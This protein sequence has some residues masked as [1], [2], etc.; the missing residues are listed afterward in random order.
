MRIKSRKYMKPNRK[1]YRRIDMMTCYFEET[2]SGNSHLKCIFIDKIK[3]H[4]AEK[5]SKSYGNI[6]FADYWLETVKDN[7]KEQ[8][9]SSDEGLCF[10]RYISLLSNEKTEDQQQ[11]FGISFL[12]EQALFIEI[13]LK[14]DR[15]TEFAAELQEI[16]NE[17]GRVFYTLGNADLVLA[18]AYDESS[19]KKQIIRKI[20]EVVNRDDVY[21]C[22]VLFGETENIDREGRIRICTDLILTEKQKNIKSRLE[23]KGLKEKDVNRGLKK[24]EKDLVDNMEEYSENRN[25]KMLAF[26]QSLLRIIRLMMQQYKKENDKNIFYI[27][28]PQVVLFLQLLGEGKKRLEN[29]EE[30][31][32]NNL[33]SINRLPYKERQVKYEAEVSLYNEEKYRI[34][35][36]I[37]QAFRDFID[38][39]EIL[40]H[41]VGHSSESVFEDRSLDLFLDDIP[42][43]LCFL[44][45]AYM[46][47]VTYL[48]SDATGNEYQYCLSPLAYSIPETECFEFGLPPKSR[49][50]K[51]MIS[52]HMMFTPRSLFII[53]SHEVSHYV[54]DKIRSRELRSECMEEILGIVSTEIFYDIDIS[55]I[56]IPE[57][58]SKYVREYYMW[59]KEHTKEFINKK[60]STL[61]KKKKNASAAKG[62]EDVWYHFRYYYKDLIC[63]EKEI[64][65]DKEWE[66]RNVINELPQKIAS[67]VRAEPEMDFIMDEIEKVQQK[68]QTQVDS[69][70]AGADDEVQKF[71]ESMKRIMKEVVAD[72]S[73][74]MLLENPVYDYLEAFVTSEGEVPDKD[75]I[76]VELL[77][78]IA[79]VV[80]VL[81]ENGY[82]NWKGD[83]DNLK[84]VLDEDYKKGN[85]PEASDYMKDLWDKVKIYSDQIISIIK[86][87]DEELEK[88]WKGDV[89]EAPHAEDFF[90]NMGIIKAENK[91]FKDCYKKI[92]E[93]LKQIER[94]PDKKRRR[95]QLLVLYQDFAAKEMGKDNS[96]DSFFQAYNK[97]VNEY[98]QDIKA[99][100]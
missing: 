96:I 85:N 19:E 81:T 90:G 12:K 3:S 61:M 67:K 16:I 25:K 26:S 43:K 4:S 64:W 21:S 56:D 53:L 69:M 92:D 22:N 83:C 31:H 71:L 89:E 29:E 30:N 51:V 34:I 78:R 66:L 18:L 63:T 73:G 93:N 40:I 39:T 24:I 7:R 38:I 41:Q 77:N 70:V 32:L 8:S 65:Y 88:E 44:Y 47:E 72:M 91:Y 27:F 10:K 5:L 15:Q 2:D 28:Y 60:I 98:K 58:A 52:R 97:I 14:T 55:D 87:P 42:I 86:K 11:D 100:M 6:N 23:R 82:K 45:I 36:E 94:N 20:S 49:L 84:R 75:T 99:G 57:S 37:E 68:V 13:C 54:N 35:G 33:E 59:S 46:H 74:I 80:T 1:I 62:L 48:L 95:E 9:C 17:T 79:M 76:T 50:I